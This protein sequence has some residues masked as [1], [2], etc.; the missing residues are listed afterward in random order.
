MPK[1]NAERQRQY[2]A[3][4]LKDPDGLLMTRL[5]VMLSPSADGALIRIVAA[6][7]KSKREVVEL[8]LLEMEKTVIV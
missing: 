1:S 7:G 3:R 8:A 6:T 2:R 5:Q 4:A